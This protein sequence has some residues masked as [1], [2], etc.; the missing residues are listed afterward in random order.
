MSDTLSLI[1]FYVNLKRHYLPHSYADYDLKHYVLNCTEMFR[2][3][4][5]IGK[6]FGLFSRL[7][8]T[9]K[10]ILL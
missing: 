9:L 5:L 2:K 1:V 8:E 4:Q 6:T 7:Q 10:F 3:S